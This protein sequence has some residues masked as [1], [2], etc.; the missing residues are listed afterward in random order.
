MPQ[1][2]PLYMSQAFVDPYV[3]C[4]FGCVYCYGFN[5]FMP[6]EAEELSD[7]RVGV[8]TNAPFLLAQHLKTL[9]SPVPV[10]LG[11]VSDPY[12]PAEEQFCLTRRCLELL[13]DAHCPIVLNTKSALVLR[14]VDLLAPASE[15]GLALVNISVS[16]MKRSLSD[17][18]EPLAPPPIDRL[19]LIKKLSRRGVLSGAVIAPVFPRLTDHP[20]D[21][22]LLI[23]TLAKHEAAYAL[24]SSL[25]LT[26]ARSVKPE[27]SP[28]SGQDATPA[29]GSDEALFWKGFEAVLS[30]NR[31]EL[32][33]YYERLAGVENEV[34]YMEWRRNVWALLTE[35]CAQYHLPMNLP[36]DG[37]FSFSMLPETVLK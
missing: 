15:K 28:E 22:R 12:Q 21:L 35:L 20:V 25:W 11:G 32:V 33:P 27:T 6:V 9:S 1:M 29:H 13:I 34:E 26:A 3:N 16:T 14:D 24:P 4:A 17:W 19:A 18:L 36:V 7:S 10:V 23:R 30:Q 5:R 2:H 8:K 31:P 37:A